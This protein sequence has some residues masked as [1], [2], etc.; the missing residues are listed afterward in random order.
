MTLEE[1]L[2]V[3]KLM[4]L[5]IAFRNSEHINMSRWTWDMAVGS[6]DEFSLLYTTHVIMRMLVLITQ[7][8]VQDLL[9]ACN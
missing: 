9:D 7:G 1:T 2:V 5:D 3:V 8:N 6:M 4:M